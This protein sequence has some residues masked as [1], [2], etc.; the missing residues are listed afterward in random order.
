[1][2][3][4]AAVAALTCIIISTAYFKCPIRLPANE[5]AKAEVCEVVRTENVLIINH[6][7]Y[8]K[9]LKSSLYHIKLIRGK[10]LPEISVYTNFLQSSREYC[11]RTI[12]T[13]LG[14]A[15]IKIFWHRIYSY[16]NIPRVFYFIRR[17]QSCI[18]YTK[19][20]DRN[21]FNVNWFVEI[22][23]I[24]G[25]NNLSAELNSTE[26]IGSRPLAVS[27]NGSYYS[28]DGAYN[29]KYSYKSI[30][31]ASFIFFGA[32]S[33]LFDFRRAWQDRCDTDLRIW[34]MAGLII[35]GW[36]SCFIGG[37]IFVGG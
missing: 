12:V 26:I 11:N 18:F 16:T 33:F 5:V 35:F 31:G 8:I 25:N 20:A 24:Y 27:K 14:F 10:F 32:L 37:I 28:S 19:V 3:A 17:S 23:R 1:M 36:F 13:I 21:I 15:K 7:P 2:R 6:T 4:R 29:S 9:P 34:I 30:E 22:V